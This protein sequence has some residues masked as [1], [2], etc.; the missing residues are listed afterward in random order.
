MSVEGV[1]RD[2]C[3]AQCGK[4]VEGMEPARLQVEEGIARALQKVRLVLDEQDGLAR[5]LEAGEAFGDVLAVFGADAGHGF[6]EQKQAGVHRGA[7]GEGEEFLL[8]VGNLGGELIGDFRKK[9]LREQRVRP[10]TVGGIALA[11]EAGR[12]ECAAELFAR[13]ARQ[14]EQDVLTH[15]ELAD[16]TQVLE[17]SRD[18]E[19][20][21]RKR[22]TT[23]NFPLAQP[24]G[25]GLGAQESANDIE[26]RGLPRSITPKQAR[27]GAGANGEIYSIKHERSAE[28][29]VDF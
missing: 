2:G 13:M 16:E 29:L 7:A 25:T 4:G 19:A 5:R 23:S 10:A 3:G 18:T 20:A 9:E 26:E 17:S 14:S 1:V 15:G 12:Q 11:L 24:D 27:D 22:G 28:G 6:V 21:D 8:A